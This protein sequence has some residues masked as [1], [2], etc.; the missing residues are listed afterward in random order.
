MGESPLFRICL[1]GQS[2]AREINS[3]LALGLF[4]HSCAQENVP[5]TFVEKHHRT[6]QNA[7]NM[8]DLVG[9]YFNHKAIK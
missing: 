4:I 8:S 5:T 7:E 2:E 9:K 3:V 1:I 6:A